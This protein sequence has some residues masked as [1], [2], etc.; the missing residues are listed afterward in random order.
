[1]WFAYVGPAHVSAAAC[2]YVD[3]VSATG[4]DSDVPK[5]PADRTPL[6]ALVAELRAAKAMSQK[7]L[8]TATRTLSPS[9]I[10]AIEAGNRA[11]SHEAVEAIADGLRVSADQRLALHAARAR[12]K[13]VLSTHEVLDDET[14]LEAGQVDVRDLD[15]EDR[16]KVIGYVHALRNK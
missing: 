5:K 9:M 3:C 11:G 14:Q 12:T 15:R 1:M 6:G 2:S 16:A 10:A 7:A 13:R 8:A 4:H